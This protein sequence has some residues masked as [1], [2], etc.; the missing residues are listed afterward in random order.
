M[1][2][3]KSFSLLLFLI[4]IIDFF[5]IAFGFSSNLHIIYAMINPFT[6]P[7]AILQPQSAFFKMTIRPKPCIIYP[8]TFWIYSLYIGLTLI[9]K[10]L[11]IAEET[12]E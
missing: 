11:F 9:K 1:Q 2:G 3:D 10:R 4:T 7:F 8:Q 12:P 5:S 6:P